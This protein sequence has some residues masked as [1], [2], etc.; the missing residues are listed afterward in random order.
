M[1]SIPEKA[2]RE[3]AHRRA[4]AS[5]VRELGVSPSLTPIVLLIFGV[6]GCA[7]SRAAPDSGPAP[8]DTRGLDKA[9]QVVARTGSSRSVIPAYAADEPVA[10][11][12][13]SPL[14]AEASGRAV[15]EE[16]ALDRMIAR[17]LS[18]RN[19][20][21]SAEDISAERERLAEALADGGVSTP[22]D[23]SGTIETLRRARGLGPMRY[24]A[25]L[26]RNASLR[27]LVG[28]AP[29]PA[30]QEITAHLE[31]R[32]GEKLNARILVL[33]SE[34][35]AAELRA[36]L[37]KDPTALTPTFARLATQRSIDASAPSGG[38]LRPFSLAEP[39]IPV[40]L[41]QVLAKLKDN[42]LSPVVAIDGGYA[43]ALIESRTPASP[44]A[45]SPTDEVR[46][47]AT[48]RLRATTQRRAMD[49]LAEELL[50]RAKVTPM[51]AGL[52]W[53]WEGR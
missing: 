8:S 46:A 24:R 49:S 20:T 21:I 52:S 38:L 53:S 39:T 37:S 31:S 23:A 41:R 4:R 15:L 43:L 50:K 14:L 3:S 42:E 2:R 12:E 34:R 9:E 25:L 27:A 33:P 11:E 30:A 36:Q 26:T 7:A 10:W 5:W 16:V 6:A 40:S 18:A 29:E 19:L 35:E 22:T 45:T 28:P 13:L 47:R 48:A 32:F 1:P 17:E 44:A 51:D